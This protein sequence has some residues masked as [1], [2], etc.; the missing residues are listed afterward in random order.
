MVRQGTEPTAELQCRRGQGAFLLRVFSA[1]FTDSFDR[2][3]D[4]TSVLGT[5]DSE[6]N[7]G[8]S[9]KPPCGAAEQCPDA[10]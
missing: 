8:A 6:T 4:P 3:L 1:H 2:L 5:E 9:V 7:N 10:F